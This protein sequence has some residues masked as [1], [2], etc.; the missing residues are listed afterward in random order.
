MATDAP[1]RH[2]FVLT[3]E[4]RESRNYRETQT[5]KHTELQKPCQ[6]DFATENIPWKVSG[7]I[8]LRQGNARVQAG[9]WHVSCGVERSEARRGAVQPPEGR[10]HG[11]GQ[12]L[13]GSDTKRDKV[14]GKSGLGLRPNEARIDFSRHGNFVGGGGCPPRPRPS[15]R[16]LHQGDEI[17]TALLGHLDQVIWHPSAPQPFATLPRSSR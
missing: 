7:I 8:P 5:G 12:A 3:M 11:L 15:G 9:F 10:R 14:Q 1:F 16:V 2:A 13:P 4:W 17:M 6:V